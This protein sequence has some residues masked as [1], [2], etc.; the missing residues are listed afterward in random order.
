MEGQIIKIE[1]KEK[2]EKRN[3]CLSEYE[4]STRLGCE[5][6][7]GVPVDHNDTKPGQRNY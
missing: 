7:A 5:P 2:K 1:S 3:S 4:G 6:R